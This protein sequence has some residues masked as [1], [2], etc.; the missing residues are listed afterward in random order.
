MIN[1]SHAVQ[2]GAEPLRSR[3]SASRTSTSARRTA[4]RSREGRL[5]TV[6]FLGFFRDASSILYEFEHEGDVEESKE[7]RQQDPGHRLQPD[8]HARAAPAEASAASTATSRTWTRCATR[9]SRTRSWSS[10]A[11]PTTSCAAPATCRL[12]R[13]VRTHSPQ[14][15]VVLTTEHIP[16]ALKFYDAGADFVYIPRLYSAAAV[17][18]HPAQGAQGRLPGGPDTGDRAP[19][20]APGGPGLARTPW[21]GGQVGT[22]LATWNPWPLIDFQDGHPRAGWLRF[23]AR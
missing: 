20:A 10:R 13:S 5:E 4:S 22:V 2:N 18:A 14:V 19:Q 16:Q 6:V 7:F 15:R 17:R 8:R 23:I 9:A 12:L 21:W 1:S 11:S 3:L